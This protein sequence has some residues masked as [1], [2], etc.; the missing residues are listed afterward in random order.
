MDK[1]THWHAN[2]NENS[3]MMI[4]GMRQ[5]AKH[6]SYVGRVEICKTQLTVSVSS[7]L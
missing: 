2:D 1:Q 5:V 4:T 7:I 6:T 3:M